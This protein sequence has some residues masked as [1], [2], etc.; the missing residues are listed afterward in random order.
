MFPVQEKLT[1]QLKPGRKNGELVLNKTMLDRLS[2]M[3][4]SVCTRA[5]SFLCAYTQYH[6]CTHHISHT[7]TLHTHTTY[8]THIT[9]HTHV[10]DTHTPHVTHTSHVSDVTHIYITCHTHREPIPRSST[11]SWCQRNSQPQFRL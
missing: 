8:H 10:T 5:Q 11:H 9:C 6:Y 1:F 4:V 2:E 3:M 7:H